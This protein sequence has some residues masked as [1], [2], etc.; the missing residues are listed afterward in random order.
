MLNSAIICRLHS[1]WK[2]TLN[3]FRVSE[4]EAVFPSKFRDSG[5]PPVGVILPRS[6]NGSGFLRRLPLTSCQYTSNSGIG[7]M[8]TG[9]KGEHQ[10]FVGTRK[11][12]QPAHLILLDWGEG[13]GHWAH[14]PSQTL[15]LNFYSWRYIS[16]LVWTHESLHFLIQ[17]QHWFSKNHNIN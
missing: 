9:P 15:I 5:I 12:L 11:P 8:T 16:T 2:E 13:S 4:N 3:L 7:L 6:Y 1:K 14:V 17:K 10:R